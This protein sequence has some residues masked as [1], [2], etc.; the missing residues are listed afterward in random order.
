ME[1]NMDQNKPNDIPKNPSTT[2]EPKEFEAT[3]RFVT[4]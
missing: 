4:V 1:N 3:V 2:M